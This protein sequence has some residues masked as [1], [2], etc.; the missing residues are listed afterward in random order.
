MEVGETLLVRYADGKPS[1][2]RNYAST[3]GAENR[4][5]YSVNYDRKWNRCTVTRTA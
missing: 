5:R 2:V 4:R 1:L 3:L